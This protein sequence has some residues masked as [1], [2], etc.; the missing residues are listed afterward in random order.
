ML[1]A[2]GIV[3]AALL[4]GVGAFAADTSVRLGVFKELRPHFDGTC[5]RVTGA[6]GTEDLTVDPRS[7]V[8][9]VSSYDRIAASHSPVGGAIYAY[10]PAAETPA[11]VRIT[12]AEDPRFRPHGISLW[13]GED[14]QAS[15]FVV[16]HPAPG[17]DDMHTIEILDFTPEGRLVPRAT[18][19]NREMLVMPNDIVAVGR[20]RFYVTN[21]HANPPGGAQQLETW[22]RRAQARV[23]YYDGAQFRAALEGRQL[24]NGINVS[25]DG[26]KLYLAE[27]SP[28]HLLVY[29]R[30][31]ASETLA[32]AS[33]IPLGSA[34]DNI[35]I[36]ENGDLWIGAHPKLIELVR[37]MG[38]HD[39]RAPSQALRVTAQGE[40]EEV[41]LNAGDQISAVSV[42][43]VRGKRLFLGQI[44]GD[45][46]LDCQQG[47]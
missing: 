45:G 25:S 26:R 7:G 14:G 36:G 3:G 29:D 6:M 35:E 22:L 21:T 4:I 16:N 5:K 37:S 20:D 30:D 24:P 41:Y 17:S 31:P 19:R 32:L 1:R 11:L 40:V 34:P 18:L 33:T 27:T 13:I 39:R 23:L 42:A 44:V 10:D 28:Q 9:Y 15:L 12:G 8:V 38:D 2:L 47:S 46:I 43:A